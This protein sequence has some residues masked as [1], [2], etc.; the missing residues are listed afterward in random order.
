MKIGVCGIACE[1]WPR[2][3]AKTYPNFPKGCTPKEK[4]LCKN[5]SCAFGYCQNISG[6][7]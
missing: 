4:K 1:K 2:L 5:A 7:G 6:K 3:V